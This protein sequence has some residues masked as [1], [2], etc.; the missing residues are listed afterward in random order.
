MRLK[1]DFMRFLR[2][3]GFLEIFLRLVLRGIFALIIVLCFNHDLTLAADPVTQTQGI[4]KPTGTA[5]SNIALWLPEGAVGEPFLPT[6]DYIA[7]TDLPAGVAYPPNS[8]GE[9]LTFGLWVGDGATLTRFIPSIVVNM[10]YEES[11]IPPAM[12]PDEDRLHLM[13]YNPTTQSWA[14]LCSSVDIHGN[15]V[16]AALTQATPLD[17]KGSSLMALAIDSTPPLEQ[18]VDE[19]GTTTISL[20]GSNLGFQVLFETVDVGSH[21]AITTL[22]GVVESGPVKL[23]SRPVDIKA[24]QIDHTSP[25]QNTRQLTSFPKS[26]RIGF[27]YD[28]DTLSR[29]GGKNRLTIVSLQNQQWIDEEALG[30]PI[31]RGDKVITVDTLTLGT[32]SMAAR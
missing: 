25:D 28:S 20:K 12:L 9:A 2:G 18:T 11:D 17:G 21:F 7:E 30:F 13:M 8:V 6:A 22:P 23:F 15:V 31:V 5:E 24:C 14:K 27:A 4:V 32:F 3:N 19:R 26:L 16:S 29:A 1:G 10:S